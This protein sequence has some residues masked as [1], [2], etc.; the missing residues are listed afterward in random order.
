MA[1]TYTVTEEYW[2]GGRDIIWTGDEASVAMVEAQLAS[3]GANGRDRSQV[4]I[5]WSRDDDGQRGYLNP[6][7]HHQVTGKAW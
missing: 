5:H 2:D 7:G 6:G 3:R 1:M 4:F